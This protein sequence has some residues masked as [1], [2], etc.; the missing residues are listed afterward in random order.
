MRTWKKGRME[1]KEAGAAFHVSHGTFYT[2]RNS[3]VALVTLSLFV[4]WSNFASAQ[5]TN[6]DFRSSADVFLR[7]LTS[8]EHQGMGGSFA[9]SI[10]GA[11]ALNSNPAGL[12]FIDSNRFV[13]HVARFPRTAAMVAKLNEAEWYEDH[14]QYDLRASGLEFINYS[15]PLGKSGAIGFD[16]ALGHEGRFSRVNHIGKA[17]GSFPENDFAAGIGYA[18][19][20]FRGLSVGV[21]ARWMRSKVQDAQVN[22]HVGHGYAYNLGLIQQFGG[23]FRIGAVIRNLSNGL[24]FTD[25]SIPDRI[26]RDVL[27]GGAYR[28]HHKDMDIQ[29]GFDLNPPFEDGIRTNFGGEI[30]Y[31]GFIGGRIG[32]LRHTEKRFDSIFIVE[33]EQVEFENRLWK[34]EGMTLGLGLKVGKINMNAAYTPQMK[35]TENEGEQIRIEQGE[36]VYSFSIGQSF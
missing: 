32:Y 9:G 2:I 17:T 7:K 8:A 23:Q 20:L 16:F 10:S 22:E 29:I 4:S 6:E 27:F 18:T 12:T 34:T 14:G 3:A 21:D 26:H 19:K 24:S 36:F 13:T 1:G 30:W 25:N 11:N 28:F 31:R 35:P 5:V 33:T 15:T